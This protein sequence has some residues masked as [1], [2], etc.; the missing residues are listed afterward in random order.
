MLD[1]AVRH[2]LILI[3]RG[4][5]RRCRVWLG[6]WV[7]LLGTGNPLK[8]ATHIPIIR[9]LIAQEL[10]HIHVVR[11]DANGCISVKCC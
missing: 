11:V 2:L 9:I 1:S 10:G 3:A 5:C 8:L 7:L 6:F 4:A